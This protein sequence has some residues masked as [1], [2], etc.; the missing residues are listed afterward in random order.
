MDVIIT[1]GLKKICQIKNGEMYAIYT[2]HMS[3]INRLAQKAQI[4][5]QKARKFTSYLTIILVVM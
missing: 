4:L 2:H 1:V 3:N 5:A